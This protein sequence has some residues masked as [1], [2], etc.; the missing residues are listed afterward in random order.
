MASKGKRKV[1]FRDLQMVR[2]TQLKSL[3]AQD[4]IS[5]VGNVAKAARE[6]N[7]EILN[8]PALQVLQRKSRGFIET[9]EALH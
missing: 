4:F 1:S 8:L 2:K 3:Q 5:A 9:M 6:K 7:L